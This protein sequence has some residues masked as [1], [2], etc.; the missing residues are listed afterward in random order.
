[1]RKHFKLFVFLLTAI[2]CTVGLIA[3]GAESVFDFLFGG[4][5]AMAMAGGV[6]VGTLVEGGSTSEDVLAAG[7][8]EDDLKKI[9]VK[10]RP[11]D[12]PL[13][14]LTREIGNTMSVSNR[15]S[16]GYEVG[17]RDVEDA[18]TLVYNGGSDVVNLRVGKKAIWQK[19]DTIHIP[20][21]LGGDGKP[22][23]L[24][25]AGK[26]NAANTLQVIAA[27]PVGGNIPAIPNETK[28]V[29]L[30]KAMGETDAQTDA[31]TT[32]PTDR[33]NYTQIHMTQVEVSQLLE[34]QNKK[35]VLDFTTHKEVAIWDWK[36]A[37]E[38]TNL[39]G[40]KSKF[41]DS[42]NNKTIYTSEGVFHQI[43]EVSE[44]NPLVAPKNSDWVRI[45]KEIFDG[46]NGADRRIVLAGSDWLA[47][48]SDI[49][50]YS[51]QQRPENVEVV[52]GVRF[53]KIITNFGELLVK[54]MSTLF[55]GDYSKCAIVLDISYVRK[56]IQEALQ[57]QELDFNK[58]GIKRVKAVR[59]LENYCLYLEN[60]PVHRKIIPQVESGTT[61]S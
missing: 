28:L 40:I 29:R 17:T 35:V 4:G 53:N 15:E 25:V 30:G 45:T 51:K 41:T 58:T 10:I 2:V 38:F 9:V 8:Q 44:Y 49:D 39:F 54:P 43:S 31:F 61:E 55:L 3:F 47:W 23:M 14:T 26:D 46:N 5:V 33:K 52:H 6:D 19:N 7:L 24:Y 32:L 48:A 34:I 12:V 36:R 20:D 56:D 11:S 50:A 37:M 27:N 22:L 21:V 13:D 1:M 60:L 16:G 57:V 42:V 18:T 59:M